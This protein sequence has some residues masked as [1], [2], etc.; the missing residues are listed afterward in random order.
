MVLRIR[1]FTS[2]RIVHINLV[3]R[4][5]GMESMTRKIVE[6][7]IAT[8]TS[9][10]NGYQLLLTVLL[11][12]VIVMLRSGQGTRTV[13]SIFAQ[14]VLREDCLGTKFNNSQ[15]IHLYDKVH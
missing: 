7:N 5:I 2:P 11:W 10:K 13:D 12:F 3:R 9:T 8:N 4:Y 15:C 1:L 6:H 14:K